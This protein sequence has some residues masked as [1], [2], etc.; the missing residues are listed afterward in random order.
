MK[1]NRLREKDVR[2]KWEYGGSRRSCERS[3]PGNKD[4]GVRRIAGKDKKII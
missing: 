1:L 4:V 3:T 2:G